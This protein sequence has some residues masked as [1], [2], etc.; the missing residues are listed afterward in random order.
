MISLFVSIGTLAI[1]QSNLQK[2]VS[3]Y[4]SRKFND[5]AKSLES[6]PK[7]SSDYASAQ[8]FLGRIA[9]DNKEYDEA[10]DRFKTATEKN[11]VNGEYFNWLGDAYAGVGSTSSFFTQMSVGPKALRAWERAAQLNPKIINRPNS[12]VAGRTK[13]KQ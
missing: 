5:A 7:S 4:E 1:G 11:P 9:Y 8:F 2:G 10:V 6:V 13:R 3:L 12:S